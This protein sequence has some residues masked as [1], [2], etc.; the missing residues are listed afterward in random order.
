MAAPFVYSLGFMLSILA[1]FGKN[2]RVWS[3]FR[4]SSVSRVGYKKEK[5]LGFVCFC[6]SIDVAVLLAWTFVDPLVFT[7]QVILYDKNNFPLVSQGLCNP[8]SPSGIGFLITVLILHL[9][10]LSALGIVISLV[11]RIP[12]EFQ[13]SR[14]GARMFTALL[15]LYLLTVPVF[16]AVNMFSIGR[17]IVLSSFVFFTVLIQLFFLFVPKMDQVRRNLLFREWQ[18]RHAGKCEVDFVDGMR[19]AFIREKFLRFAEKNLVVESYFFYIVVENFKYNIASGATNK[20]ILQQAK[21]I[22]EMYI[23]D[24]ALFQISISGDCLR[25]TTK[26]YRRLMRDASGT[27]SEPTVAVANQNGDGNATKPTREDLAQVFQP[28]V[29]EVVNLLNFSA[30]KA[31]VEEGGMYSSGVNHVREDR[32]TVTRSGH[33]SSYR[34]SKST[35]SPASPTMSRS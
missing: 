13:E 22:Y 30:W 15:L 23:H 19:N 1:L 34:K 16:V 5:V 14:Y 32:S 29:L 25:Q 8:E 31:F 2:L 10:A 20:E 27:L 28:A 18:F 11:K 12:D 17:F 7:R 35:M 6:L 24:D 21:D 26:Y 33:T 4:L 9:L 3:V